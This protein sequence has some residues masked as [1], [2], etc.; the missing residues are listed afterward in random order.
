LILF[1]AIVWLGFDR[2]F[3]V[4]PATAQRAGM[5]PQTIRTSSPWV[6]A[7][8]EFPGLGR[9]F[10]PP[11]DEGSFLW[12]PTTMPH[13]SLGEALEVL[14]YQDMAIASI[15]EVDNVTGKLAEP[16]VRWILRQF[17]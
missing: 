10:M 8:H 13:A 3:G 4:I 2:M 17:L 12:M 9:E 14:Q 15:P 6:W 5:D 16:K 1:G 7:S 11:L